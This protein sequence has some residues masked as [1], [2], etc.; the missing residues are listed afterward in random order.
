M[1]DFLF[2]DSLIYSNVSAVDPAQLGAGNSG[3]DLFVVNTSGGQISVELTN[4]DGAGYTIE[5]IETGV[6]QVEL[7]I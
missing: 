1:S 4:Q 6:F 7:T 3:G 5:E 2:G